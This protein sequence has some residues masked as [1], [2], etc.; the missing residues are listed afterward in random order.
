VKQT[1]RNL[2]LIVGGSIIV[3]VVLLVFGIKLLTNFSMLVENKPEDTEQTSSQSNA[4]V[5]T[6]SLDPLPDATNSA[7]LSVSGIAEGSNKASLY[8]NGVKTK[9][10]DVKDDGTFL[11]RN[12]TLESGDNTIKV[13]SQNKSG[14]ES[15]F[16]N[17]VTVTYSNKAPDLTVDFPT[18]GQTYHKDDNPLR[19]R[20]KT[21]PH[22]R[23]TV[24]DFWAII[25]D[26]GNFSYNLPLQS[27]DNQIKVVAIDD[28]GNK[29]EKDL[30]V[31][32]SE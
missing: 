15:S 27:G 30:K 32:Y 2:F 23:V 21:S 25:D 3:V 31:S 17:T 22:T 1:E 14:K 16:S 5:S 28:A 8:L 10:A 7:T 12:V 19:V 29:T 18:D 24:N 9:D 4:F 6:P 11:F 26:E 13:K 20:G